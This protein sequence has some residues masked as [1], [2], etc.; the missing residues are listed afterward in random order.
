MP[1]KTMFIRKRMILNKI[2]E[3]ITEVLESFNNFKHIRDAG[4]N[5]FA[6]FLTEGVGHFTADF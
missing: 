2:D 6:I 4:A 1:Q 3:I 5:I